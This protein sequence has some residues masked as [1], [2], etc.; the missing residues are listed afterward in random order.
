MMI[1]GLDLWFWAITVLGLASFLICLFRFLRGAAPDE[2]GRASC[3]ER[4]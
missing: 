1:A 3:R 2:I 4:V